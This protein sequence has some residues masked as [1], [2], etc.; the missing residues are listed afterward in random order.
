MLLATRGQLNPTPLTSALWGEAQYRILQE[1][2]NGIL[3][4]PGNRAGSREKRGHP[5]E[6]LWAELAGM[7]SPS[8][9]GQDVSLWLPHRLY[10]TRI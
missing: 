5:G 8:H 10:S 2:S 1:S 3:A 4:A 6:P 9:T 7:P